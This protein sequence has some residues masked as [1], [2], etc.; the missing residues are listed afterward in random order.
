MLQNTRYDSIRYDTTVTERYLFRLC[1]T[2]VRHIWTLQLY[3]LLFPVIDWNKKTAGQICTFQMELI[4]D[5]F[6][7][8]TC[9]PLIAI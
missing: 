1:Q 3:F 8:L 4:I 6:I 5:D 2:L 9:A 7:D